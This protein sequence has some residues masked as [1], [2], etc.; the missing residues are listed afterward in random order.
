MVAAFLGQGNKRVRFLKP[1]CRI[2]F[3]LRSRIPNY[4]T[5]PSMV[6]AFLGQEIRE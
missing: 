3:R 6:A 5:I 1:C 4:L 2:D